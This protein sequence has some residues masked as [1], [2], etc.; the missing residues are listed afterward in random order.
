MDFS[1]LLLFVTLG[2]KVASGLSRK[3]A[4]CDHPGVVSFVYKCIHQDSANY[5]LKHFRDIPITIMFDLMFFE[6][7]SKIELYRHMAWK[8]YDIGLF[9]DHTRR[10]VFED[11]M[12]D[13]VYLKDLKNKFKKSFKQDLQFVYAAW[14]M[15]LEQSHT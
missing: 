11:G 3:F 2:L 1:S 4:R 9:V 10:K 6:D 12:D 15:T 14:T 7:E 13:P 8:G 5:L